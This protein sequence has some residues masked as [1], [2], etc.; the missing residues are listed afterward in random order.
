MPSIELT[1]SHDVW[2]NVSEDHK[3]QITQLIIA[4]GLVAGDVAFKGDPT[5]PV[6]HFPNP[7]CNALC[8]AAE[9]AAVAACA[10]ITDGVAFAACLAAAHSAADYCHGKC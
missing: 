2:K 5:L 8:N 7:F 3:K 10:A 9:A 1:I 6:P 4:H